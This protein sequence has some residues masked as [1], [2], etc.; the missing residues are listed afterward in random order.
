MTTK[1]PVKVLQEKPLILEPV[2]IQPLE[3][4]TDCNSAK[5][6]ENVGL[7][8]GA[9]RKSS[10]TD[11]QEASEADPKPKRP[12][13]SGVRSIY[14]KNQDSAGDESQSLLGGAQTST[15]TG[16]GKSNKYGETP[17]HV[18][19]RK[20]DLAKVESLLKNQVWPLIPFVQFVD[21]PD[22]GKYVLC[23]QVTPEFARRPVNFFRGYGHPSKTS[24]ILMHLIHYLN[25][26]S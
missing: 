13:R 21:L 24:H 2:L 17:L 3:A 1:S 8:I 7:T 12:R 5:E 9:K 19:A 15:R 25:V 22:Q 18:A 4:L 26:K 10:T 23:H 11:S 16:S 6:K 20:G 14:A